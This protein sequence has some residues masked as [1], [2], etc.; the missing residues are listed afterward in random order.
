MKSAQRASQDLRQAISNHYTFL[1]SL[2]NITEE[3]SLQIMRH[4][5]I[6]AFVGYSFHT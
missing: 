2:V 1:N 5:S 4:S 3:L 6:L